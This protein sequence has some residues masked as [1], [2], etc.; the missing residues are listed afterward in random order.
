MLLIKIRRWR[1]LFRRAA[2]AEHKLRSATDLLER[3]LDWDAVIDAALRDDETVGAARAL[4]IPLSE[5]RSDLSHEDAVAAIQDV[6]HALDGHD[7]GEREAVLEE[8]KTVL[9]AHVCKRFISR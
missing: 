9:R 1:L 5:L 7:E 3:E 8:A 6:L 2:R 4:G